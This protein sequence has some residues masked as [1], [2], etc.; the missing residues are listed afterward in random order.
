ME[1]GTRVFVST[2]QFEGMATI[3]YIVANEMYPVQVK[4]DKPDD[5]G[6]AIKRIAFHEIVDHPG[7]IIGDSIY[8]F[9]ENPDIDPVIVPIKRKRFLAVVSKYRNGYRIGDQYIISEKGENGFF[10]V[11][12]KNKPYKNPI[13]SYA[14]NFLTII[15]PYDETKI[16]QV[17]KQPKQAEIEEIKESNIKPFEQAKETKQ[18]EDLKP[19]DTKKKKRSEILEEQ[20]NMFEFLG[21]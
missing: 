7:E 19:I 15:E 1:I 3:I 11:Y 9:N 13:G 14:K 8:Y 12:L 18:S 5:D 20:L 4:L 6:H 2:K 16:D 10:H 21:G 17:I